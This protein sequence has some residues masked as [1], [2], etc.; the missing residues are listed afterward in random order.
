[1]SEDRTEIDV[2]ELKYPQ[3][4]AYVHDPDEVPKDLG[5]IKIGGTDRENA[6]DRIREQN[7]DSNGHFK[8]STLWIEPSVFKN[9]GEFFTDHDLHRYL[10]TVKDVKRRRFED[11]NE[12]SEWFYYNGHPEASHVHFEDFVNGDFTQSKGEND[13]QLREEQER[14]V[15]ETCAYFKRHKNSKFLWNAKPR[16]GKTLTTYDLALKMSAKNVLIVTNRPAIA[17]S[18]MDDFEKFIAWKTPETA[19]VSETSALKKRNSLGFKEFSEMMK[20]GKFEGM[21]AFLSLQD[22][23]GGEFFGGKH[24]K[25]EWVAETEWDLLVIDESHE[26]V[27]TVKTDVAFNQ[28]EAKNKLYLS[29]TPFKALASG[30]FSQDQIFNW[31]YVDEQTAKQEWNSSSETNNPYETLPARL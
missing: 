25:L 5:W 10:T 19:F 18:W 13:Y 29:G 28:I 16:F 1:M 22:L 26:G 31:T 24:Q 6:E 15:Q 11:N 7:C 30:D 9:T 17:N 8:Y 27:D 23:K 20:D 3:I 21:F 4:Y 2:L 12:L 14:A